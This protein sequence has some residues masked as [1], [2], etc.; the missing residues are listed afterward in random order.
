MSVTTKEINPQM[1]MAE[2]M[3]IFPGAKRAL[4]QKY[5]IGGCN[6]CGFAP[7]D[8]LEQVFVKHNRPAE[9][10]NAVEWIYESARVD[11]EMQISPKELKAALDA[12]EEW[13]IVDVRDEYEAEIASIPGGELITREMAYEI[14]EKWPK[15][16]K[17]AFYCHSGFRSLEATSYF[18]GHGIKNAK[19]LSGGID[20]WSQEIDSTIPRY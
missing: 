1:Q 19:S 5:H 3:D 11:A 9:T 15:D 7:T 18:K 20:L 2:I 4:F 6:S 13:K 14:L 8:T 16:T 10:S 17:I 12:G